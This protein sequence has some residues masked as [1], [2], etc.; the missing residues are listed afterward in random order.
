MARPPWSICTAAVLDAAVG[1]GLALGGA[2]V[3]LAGGLAAEGFLRGLGLVA[4]AWGLAGVAAGIF[5]L[6]VAMA[7]WKGASWARWPSTVLAVGLAPGA[8]LLA[9]WTGQGAL[10]LLVLA[11]PALATG[12]FLPGARRHVGTAAAESQSL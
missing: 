10:L 12:L 1:T 8:V 2:W 5:L 6:W 9:V 11:G 7:L 3:A 4:I